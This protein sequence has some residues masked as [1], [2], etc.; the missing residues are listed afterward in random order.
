MMKWLSCPKISSRRW[1]RKE[2]FN[3]PP[4]EKTQEWKRNIRRKTMRSSDSNVEN[5]DTWRLSS[6]VRRLKQV[7]VQTMN[8]STSFWWKIWTKRM[9]WKL[10]L[11]LNLLIA[12]HQ[13]MKKICPM[14]FFFR[15]V[16]WFHFSAKRINKNIMHLFLKHYAEEIKWYSRKENPNFK[17]K[18]DLG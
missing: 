9:R 11:N 7:A 6:I 17:T 4:K 10:V 1:K 15:I 3:T 2:S 18:C 8:K 12:L 5:L 13:T 16:I 14:M